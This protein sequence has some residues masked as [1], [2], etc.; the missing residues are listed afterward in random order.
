M[1]EIQAAAAQPPAAP[2]AVGPAAEPTSRFHKILKFTIWAIV[3]VLVIA[4]LEFF[5]V[6]VTGWIADMWD[7]IK[8]VPPQYIL[9]GLIFKTG[10]S[11]LTAF[12]WMNVLR[13]VYPDKHVSYK[14]ALG[15][16]QGGVGINDIAPAKAG[17]WT[18]LG[19]FRLYIPGSKLATLMSAFAV[20][21][22]AFGIFGALNY[23]VLFIASPDGG[24]EAISILDTLWD[25]ISARPGLVILIVVCGGLLITIAVRAYWVKIKGLKEQ[26]VEG[27]AILKTPGRYL[28]L[29]FLPALLSYVCRW[30]YTGIFMA[31][32]DIPVT[33][34]TV[35]LVIASNA[36]AGALGLT[37][38]GL[39]TTQAADAVVLRNY[40]STANATAYSLAQDAILT[41]WNLVFGLI[42]MSWAFGWSET[43]QLVHDRKQV[44]QRMEQEEQAEKTDSDVDSTGAP[45]VSEEPASP[46]SG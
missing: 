38:G 3:I 43:K 36:I 5:G 11:C 25:Y 39:G 10:E 42:V 44:S 45:S 1:S 31:A 33:L 30:V 26:F 34:Y 19:L 4:A 14:L 40:T 15:A 8:S 17:T 29:V 28:T 35:F 13:A 24:A 12:S 37:P 6:D 41:A 20:Q 46:A 7:S 22:I 9:A 23:V 27:G 21:S 18:M 16:Y 32:F 2:E